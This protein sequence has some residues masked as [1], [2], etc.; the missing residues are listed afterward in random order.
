VEAFKEMPTYLII[1]PDLCIDCNACVSECPVDAIY[2][3]EEVPQDEIEW[4]EKNEEESID[5]DVAEGDSPV[6]GD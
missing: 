6:L 1:D 5:A 2:P 3:E 4:I